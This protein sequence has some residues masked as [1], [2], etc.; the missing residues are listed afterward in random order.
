MSEIP[1]LKTNSK[2]TLSFLFDDSFR[3]FESFGLK[4]HAEACR[5][6]I[7]L[8]VLCSSA[9]RTERHDVGKPQ[10]GVE[11]HKPH[12]G[13][14][15]EQR[16]PSFVFVC[17]SFGQRHNHQFFVAEWEMA[18]NS[19]WEDATLGTSQLN[20]VDQ[21]T[22]LLSSLPTIEWTIKT[23]DSLKREL[24]SLKTCLLNG[25]T[26]LA[27]HRHRRTWCRILFQSAH[28]F[29]RVACVTVFTIFIQ[30]IGSCNVSFP[31]CLSCPFIF[32]NVF[33]FLNNLP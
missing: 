21:G 7:W 12:A 6:K 33:L 11:K 10:V 27:V 28:F 16:Y 15:S 1:S 22:V 29:M 32:E 25:M 3:S 8:A 4:W 19:C 17:L 9:W 13:P 20:L 24:V 26:L 5:A 23:D 2:S 31:R 18:T 30:I 14:T